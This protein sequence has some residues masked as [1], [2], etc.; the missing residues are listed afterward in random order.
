MATTRILEVTRGRWRLTQSRRNLFLGLAFVSPWIVGFIAWWVVP[1]A[2]TLWFSF[3]NYDIINPPRAAGISNYVRLFTEDPT[4]PIVLFNT[5]YF[6]AIAVPLGVV[7]AYL[8][9]SLLNNQIVIR[10][11]FRICFFIPVLVPDVAIAMVWLWIYH[12]RWGLINSVLVG[13]GLLAI[14]WLGA[15]ELAKLSLIIINTWHQGIAVVIFLAALQDVPRELYEAAKVDGADKFGRWRHITIPLTTPAILFVLITSLVYA[16][17]YFTIGWIM[18]EGGPI[19]STRFYALY[20]YQNAF[21]FFRM[22]YASA[23]SWIMFLVIV[24]ITLITFKTS[25]GWVY[26]ARE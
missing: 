20:L 3:T 19:N 2:A 1:I 25:I 15:P 18:T 22:G 8:L 9:A 26:Y 13:S 23:L 10:P 24:A 17:Q 12:T 14:P 11:F 5:V 16:F 7:V 21:Q 4:F 6:V